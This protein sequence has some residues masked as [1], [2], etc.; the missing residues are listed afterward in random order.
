MRLFL[1]GIVAALALG[2][3]TN[4]AFAQATP[5]VLAGISSEYL[6]G[7]ENSLQIDVYYGKGEKISQKVR[8][9][10]K[11]MINYPLVGEVEATGLT[12]SGLQDKL[13]SLLSKDYLVNPQVTIYI[14]EYST[15]S[16][17][18]EVKK[19]GAYPIKG[20]LSIV[21][22]ISLAEG[23]TKIASPNKV[24]VIRTNPDGSKD[25]KL[26]RVYDLMNKEGSGTENIILRSGDV[27]VV[28]ESLF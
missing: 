18:G 28:P 10:S 25:E 2:L 16:V 1:L 3:F 12:V 20:Q 13:T 22:L 21:E 23:F 4:F 9:S 24:K 11:G 5:A 6:I 26:I 15:V 17:M 19:P 7:P 14:E 8:V 27:V